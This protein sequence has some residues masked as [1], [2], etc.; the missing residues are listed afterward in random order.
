MNEQLVQENKQTHTRKAPDREAL[1]CILS[2]NEAGLL[3]NY[4]YSSN[5]R[6]LTISLDLFGSF[7]GNFG[8]L[9]YLVNAELPVDV[10]QTR[11]VFEPSQRFAEWVV[12]AL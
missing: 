1:D 8:K 5:T 6:K 3:P 12:R 4:V 9:E 7:E 10:S 11:V 2:K